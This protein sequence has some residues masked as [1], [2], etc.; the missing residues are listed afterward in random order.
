M[1]TES[2][3]APPSYRTKMTTKIKGYKTD[4]QKFSRDL[5]AAK[6]SARGGGGVN[7]RTELLSGGGDSWEVITVNI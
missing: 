5:T 6:R 7:D 2:R 1:E 4:V 3:T